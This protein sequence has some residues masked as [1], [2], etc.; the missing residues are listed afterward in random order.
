MYEFI[1]LYNR[2][3]H[4]AADSIH[5]YI[6]RKSSKLKHFNFKKYHPQDA[7]IERTIYYTSMNNAMKINVQKKSLFTSQPHVMRWNDDIG[8]TNSLFLLWIHNLTFGPCSRFY[9]SLPNRKILPYRYRHRLVSP[10]MHESAFSERNPSVPD[11]RYI[12][13]ITTYLIWFMKH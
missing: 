8:L 12:F 11:N 3:W 1:L 2:L 5:I 4:R 10:S 9:I 6:Y 7:Y 13:T